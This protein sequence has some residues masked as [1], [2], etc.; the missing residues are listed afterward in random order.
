MAI[1]GLNWRRRQSTPGPDAPVWLAVARS[2]APH[3]QSLRGHLSTLEK[4]II[5]VTALLSRA[6]KFQTGAR[7]NVKAAEAGV[8]QAEARYRGT[9][10]KAFRDLRSGLRWQKNF[11]ENCLV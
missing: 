11:L 5:Y 4:S 10:I 6:A 2:A 1:P 3:S 8:E 9:A 7:Q